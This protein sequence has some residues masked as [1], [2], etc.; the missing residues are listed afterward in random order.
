LRIVL[1]P[2]S[3]KGLCHLRLSATVPSKFFPYITFLRH[4]INIS[5]PIFSSPTAVPSIF[6]LIPHYNH[7]I[8]FSIHIF[9]HLS[10]FHLLTINRGPTTQYKGRKRAHAESRGREK[11]RTRGCTV[12]DTLEGSGAAP[13]GFLLPLQKGRGSGRGKRCG[14][15]NVILPGT[16][17]FLVE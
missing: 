14:Q 16:T 12:G 10:I 6:F 15:P 4:I 7:K 1:L 11:R 3:I 9:Y 17:N 2:L 5:S 13:G 8:S